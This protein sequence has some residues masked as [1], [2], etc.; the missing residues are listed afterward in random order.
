MYVFNSASGLLRK[1]RYAAPILTFPVGCLAEAYAAY[2]KLPT[3]ES[4]SFPWIVV[5]LIVPGNLIGGLFAY[6]AL[7]SKGIA[8]LR[9]RAGGD[10]PSAKPGAGVKKGDEKKRR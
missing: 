6:P 9:G 10:A 5:A 4:G 7:V 2:E 1:L 8:E 3:M